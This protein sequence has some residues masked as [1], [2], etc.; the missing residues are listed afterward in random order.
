[1]P[2]TQRLLAPRQPGDRAPVDPQP[3]CDLP[4]RNPIRRQRPHLRPLQ[5]A[6]HLRTSRSTTPTGRASKTRRTGDQRR[7]NWCTFRLPIPVQY[8]TPGVTR[9]CTLA[10]PPIWVSRSGS[11]TEDTTG[12]ARGS[13]NCARVRSSGRAGL[14]PAS[15]PFA[16]PAELN[17]FTSPEG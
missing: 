13:P 16:L 14:R 5:R 3:L 10:L 2:I 15:S 8:W 9:R 12:R 7:G 11:R 4:L 1:S 6:P 17:T